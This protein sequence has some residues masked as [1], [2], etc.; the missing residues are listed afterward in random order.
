[1][2]KMEKFKAFLKQSDEDPITDVDILMEGEE[3]KD[4]QLVEEDDEK[5]EE[6]LTLQEFNEEKHPTKYNSVEDKY[7]QQLLLDH[8]EKIVSEYMDKN[9]N[10]KEEDEQS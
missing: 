3:V 2:N 6:L 1:M 9:P 4:P 10:F 8:V 5:I 7:E